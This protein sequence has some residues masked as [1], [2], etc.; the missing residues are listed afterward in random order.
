L[1]REVAIS[2][3][4]QGLITEAEF[5]KIVILTTNGQLVPERPL[6]DDERRDFDIRM[7]RHFREYLG[8]Q[9]KSSLTLRRH[10]RARVL[11]IDFRRK[12]PMDSD[13]DYWYFLAH[14]DV[15]AMAF[16]DPVFLVP[17]TFL[18]K[19]GRDGKR[20]GAIQFQFK[21]SMEPN[22]RDR[23]APYRLSPHELGPRIRDL[24]QSQRAMRGTQAAP[25]L[26]GAPNIWWV[27]TRATAGRVTMRSAA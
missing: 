14:F 18:H 5:A 26:P 24:L 22:S 21:A 19:Y 16:S 1:H 20:R 17:S 4:Q 7:R 12:P 27:T 6:A 9:A 13:P 11:R 8:I 10:G 3:V 15:H 23:W 2:T 25:G